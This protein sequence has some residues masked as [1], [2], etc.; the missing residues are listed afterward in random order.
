MSTA[1]AVSAQPAAGPLPRELRALALALMPGAIMVGLDATM[2]NVALETLARDFHTSIATIQWVTTAYLLALAMV[3]PLSGWAIERYGARA[4]WTAALALF[5]L[6]S[7]LCGLA[8]S[9]GSLIAFRVVQGLGGGMIV[10]VMQTTLARAAGPARLPRVMAVIGVPAMLAPV[11]GP[12]LGG[13]LVSNASWRL[14]F[15]INVPICLAALLLTTRVV[16][17]DTR[18]PAGARLDLL[19]L[20]LLSTAITAV[21]YG[22]AQAGATGS[23]ADLEVLVP[24]VSGLALLLAFAVHA[25]RVGDAAIVDVRLFKARS[26]TGSS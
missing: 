23:F 21:V 7:I 5:T 8:W 22:L 20:I 15:Y 10:P 14:I 17:P 19:G 3:I 24:A 12:V 9:A 26:F 6:G 1:T 25:L 4:A 13:L 16:L 18:T 2:V 11:L